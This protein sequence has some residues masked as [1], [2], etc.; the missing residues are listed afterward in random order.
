VEDFTSA[1][2]N[3][4]Q[5]DSLR[6][7]ELAS[8]WDFHPVQ[9]ANMPGSPQ[10][11]SK[12][13]VTQMP[14]LPNARPLLIASGQSTVTQNADDHRQSHRS[15]LDYGRLRDPGGAAAQT[16]DRLLWA[17]QARP[18]LEAVADAA[19]YRVPDGHGLAKREAA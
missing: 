15:G 18:A 17:R 3:G 4:L 14:V 13:A 12:E 5:L 7:N 10:N 1:V 11:T 6:P 16:M 8:A 9:L 2:T 19:Q